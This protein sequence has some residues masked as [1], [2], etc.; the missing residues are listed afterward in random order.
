MNRTSRRAAE[1]DALPH[2]VYVLKDING[3]ALYVGCTSDV[4]RRLANHSAVQPWWNEVRVKVSAGPMHRRRALRVER[5]LIRKLRPAHN[6]VSFEPLPTDPCSFHRFCG[7][8][9]TT[10]YTVT[11]G[12]IR[13]ERARTYHVCDEHR[14]RHTE[15]GAA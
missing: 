15:A 6:R 11:V 3:R 1:L 14:S 2:S 12:D 5:S 7:N 8:E 9:A 4:P 13:G 10:S